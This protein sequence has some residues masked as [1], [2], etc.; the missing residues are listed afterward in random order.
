MMAMRR[1]GSRVLG[2]LLAAV[3]IAGTFGVALADGPTG[4][5]LE[6]APPAKE[7]TTKRF[8]ATYDDTQPGADDLRVKEGF[9]AYQAGDFKKAYDIW[10]PLA[11]AGNAEAQFRI[12]RLYRRGEGVPEDSSIAALYWAKAS[13]Q[14]HLSGMQNLGVLYDLGEGVERNQYKAFE[15]YKY[16]A[17]H[18]NVFAQFSLGALYAQTYTPEQSFP[19]AYQWL[20]I[21]ERYGYQY[22]TSAINALDKYTIE[23]EK[24]LGQKGM[25]EWLANHSC[26]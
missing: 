8:K 24:I 1:I 19:L 9:A 16:A 3:L 10:L 17:S 5:P 11:E 2:V 25:Q 15:L 21:A 13:L 23:S 6:T 12:G 14:Y 7:Q 26:D 22:A 18:C 4:T 20:F